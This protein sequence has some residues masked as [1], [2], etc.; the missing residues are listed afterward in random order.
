MNSFPV[1]KDS[2]KLKAA[3]LQAALSGILLSVGLVSPAVSATP[4]H[5]A[6]ASP[7]EIDAAVESMMG[8]RAAS[9]P[10]PARG[11]EVPAPVIEMSV[12][13]MQRREAAKQKAIGELK[14]ANQSMALKDYD[15][16]RQH[17]LAVL[18]SLPESRQAAK[19]RADALAGL[20]DASIL[21]AKV[22]ISEGRYTPKPGQK[23]DSAEE[24]LRVLLERDPQ[25][26]SALRIL[27]QLYSPGYYNKTI[28]PSYRAEVSDVQTKLLEGQG[29]YDTGRFDLAIKRADQVLDI[30]PYNSAARKLQEMANNAI[31]RYGD[32]AYNEARSRAMRNVEKAWASPIKRYGTVSA[33]TPAPQQ[34]ETSKIEKLK[35]KLESIVI[36]EIE[37]SDKP[38][39]LVAAALTQLSRQA[40]K[41]GDEQKGI[42]IIA[43]FP[44]A[45]SSG[46]VGA[47]P[48]ASLQSLGAPAGGAAAGGAA[49][50]PVSIPKIPN[51]ALSEILKI[52][53]TAADVKW[54]IK[55][56]YV[57]FV[58]KTVQT[59][60]LILQSWTVSPFM[61]SSTAPKVDDL[62]ST[63]LGATLSASSGANAAA[64]KSTGRRRIDAKEFLQSMNVRF[65]APGST[66]TYNPRSKVLTVYN[67]PDMLQLVDYIVADSEGQS[68]V[69]VDIQAKFIEF[70]QT[71]LK[72]LSFDWLMGQS[73]VPG[74]HNVFVGGGTPGT[75]T[76]LNGADYPFTIP[77]NSAYPNAGS[78]V[79]VYPMTSGNRTSLSSNAIDALLAGVTGGATS[80]APG[81][82]S[83]AGA[84]TDPQ[85]QTV[86]RA[87]NQS[88]GV[89]LLSSPSVT[90]KDQEEAS[91]DI[92][93]LFRYPTEFTPPQVPPAPQQNNTNGAASSQGVVVTPTTPSA[94]DT[95]ET[96]VKLKVTPSIKGDNY[97]IDL[98]LKPEVTEFEGFINY[99]SPIQTVAS[100]SAL[101]A[102][103]VSVGVTPQAVTLTQNVINQP[104]FSVRRIQTNVTLLDGETIA[105]GGLIRE[106]V[107]KINDKV[108]ILGDIPLLGRLFRSNV[109]QHIKKNLTIFVTARIMDASGQPIKAGRAELEPPEEVPSLTGESLPR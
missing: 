51:F 84:F 90:A 63:G 49:Y 71:N 21:L 105:L 75:G 42:L 86:V 38:L 43:N 35:K 11:T 14:Q 79:G 91:I 56:K 2:R 107:Q 47:T 1:H 59:D 87:L 58:P 101:N 99:G 57:E 7:A 54:T 69:Q 89:D 9:A 10:N 67:S 32:D 5:G 106:D 36:P 20:R 60:T 98:D 97:A 4:R 25:N 40:D 37:F 74:N 13:E 93:R 72:E 8:G 104:I 46:G 30:D 85:F 76:S 64:S 45:V 15:A 55:E 62:S 27:E 68:P 73:N 82:F 6:A 33:S 41:S 24:V 92:V 102:N 31:Q 70:S 88:K 23:V 65:D 44:G 12:K 100:S 78:P 34:I 81:M 103:G 28:S 50:P 94:Y 16:A 61:F 83:V 52:I 95:K 26:R 109:D 22:R 39:D 17:Y 108:P 29:F 53:A 19:E 3:P 77:A 48:G 66:A 18:D 96:G 80:A